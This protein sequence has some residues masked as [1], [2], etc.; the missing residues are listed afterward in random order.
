MLLFRKQPHLPAWV[1]GKLS[2][3]ARTGEGLRGH[4]GRHKR[5]CGHTLRSQPGQSLPSHTILIPST[6]A[7]P[8]CP[9]L[10]SDPKHSSFH[11]FAPA[12]P[13]TKWP[14]PFYCTCPPGPQGTW[15]APHFGH[16]ALYACR[17]YGT[18]SRAPWGRQGPHWA[19]EEAG[20]PLLGLE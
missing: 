3:R 14:P 9:L 6:P 2:S 11:A 1:P 18:G 8:N 13:S 4:L 5:A 16:L 20:S 10:L 12:E 19:L 17:P 15:P 7:A